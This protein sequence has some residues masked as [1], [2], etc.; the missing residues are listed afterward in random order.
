[1]CVRLREL[2]HLREGGH[3][4]EDEL[5]HELEHGDEFALGQDPF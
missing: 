4:L 2:Y 3:E 5:E 1:M